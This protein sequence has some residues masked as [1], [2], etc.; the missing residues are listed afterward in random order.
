MYVDS[1]YYEDLMLDELSPR[2]NT[3]LNLSDHLGGFDSSGR[4]KILD[5]LLVKEFK[6]HI[7]LE[8]LL[9]EDI[10]KTYKDLDLHFSVEFKSNLDLIRYKE[11]TTHPEIDFKNFLCSFNRSQ[12][13]GRQ[14]LVSILNKFKIFKPGYCSK[15]FEITDNRI[16]GYIQSF[17]DMSDKEKLVYEKFF[18]TD[19]T[20]LKT[21]YEL[22][23]I[24]PSKPTESGSWLGKD[25]CMELINNFQNK[26]TESFVYL[27]S[28]SVA[29]GY[30]PFFTEKFLLGVA[31]R[32][33]FITYGQ[34]QWYA[35]LEKYFGFRKYDIFDYSFDSIRNPVIRVVELVNMLNKFS[36][37]SLFELHDLYLSEMDNIEF[38]YNHYFSDD[39]ERHL[40]MYEY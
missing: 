18:T 24:D 22:S 26:V 32:S 38:N 23:N 25:Y 35:H 27:A 12:N 39:Y 10:R 14:L 2:F 28:E 5:S 31:S 20:F 33:L 7:N 37:L 21:K 3:E 16:F 34:P 6:H 1:S 29:E 11:H 9:T 40:K 19:D 36:N 15:F 8:Y 17:D 30:Y 4:N 13:M